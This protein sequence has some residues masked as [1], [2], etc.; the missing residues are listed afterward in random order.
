AL[1]L[2][3][4]LSGKK[5]NAAPPT[6]PPAVAPVIPSENVPLS[7]DESRKF[8]WSLNWPRISHTFLERNPET[9]EVEF[10]PWGVLAPIQLEG[11]RTIEEEKEVD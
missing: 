7:L 4:N 11:S 9:E 3:I 2:I 10:S 6:P 8:D 1:W 5:V